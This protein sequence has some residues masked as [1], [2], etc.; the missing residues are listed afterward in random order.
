MLEVIPMK[1]RVYRAEKLEK[2]NVEKLSTE[3]F[4]QSIVFGI[5]VAKE[6]FYG[7]LMNESCEVVKT[8][9]WKSPGQV[10][11]LVAFLKGLPANRLQVALEPSGTYGDALRVLLEKNRIDVFLVSPKR[12]KD[13]CEVYDGVPSSHDAKSAAIIAKLH[14]DGMSRIWPQEPDDAR[15]LSA[16]MDLMVIYDE[17]RQRNA[18]RMEAKLARYWPE[19]SEILDIGLATSLKLLEEFGGP[20]QVAMNPEESLKLMKKAGRC[21]L[22]EEKC[23]SIIDSAKATIGVPMIDEECRALS[24]LAKEI[25]RNRL[26]GD[27]A[28]KRVEALTIGD[29]KLATTSAAV[30]KVTAAMLTIGL[31]YA[32]E[33]DS[34]SAFLKA[35][36]LNLKERSSGKH[37]GQLKITKR[38]PGELRRYLYLAVL[39]LIQRDVYFGAWYQKKVA[40]DGGRYK[41]RAIVALMRKLLKALWHVGQ[42]ASFDTQ[43]LFDTSRLEIKA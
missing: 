10:R 36:G 33:Y 20:S 9:K 42:G 22:S 21:A 4:G 5:D 41:G 28:K 11:D 19:L 13:A 6:D 14:M 25:N 43:R 37:Q 15:K 40:R 27:S 38:G 35:G 7:A 34:A 26:E 12:S 30:G 24:E 2:V 39:R 29:K 8:I 32:E 23:R 18:N 1:K 17:Q 31:G 3:I 16:A